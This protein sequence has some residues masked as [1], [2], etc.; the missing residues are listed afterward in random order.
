MSGIA[1]VKFLIMVN[2]G[3]VASPVYS[4]IGGQQGAT[5]NRS[6]DEIN[7]SS[8]DS[9]GWGASLAG[10]RTW[11]IEGDGLLYESDAALDMLETTFAAG[12]PVLVQ[13]TTPW[14]TKYQGTAYITDLSIEAPH[15]GAATI[16]YTL[17]G[18][19]KLETVTS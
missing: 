5:L 15:D 18:N 4:A 11:S 8:K 9:D 1:G 2:I 10:L 7:V 12:D 13:L 6:A 16:S 19:G 17:S 3:T 14:S